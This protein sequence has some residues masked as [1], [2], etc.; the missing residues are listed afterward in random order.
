MTRDAMENDTT[1]THEVSKF[2]Y[3]SRLV[4]ESRD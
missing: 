2:L 1:Q 3:Y 4:I